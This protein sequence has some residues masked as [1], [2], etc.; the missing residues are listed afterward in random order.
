MPRPVAAA[1]AALVCGACTSI[2]VGHPRDYARAELSCAGRTYTTSSVANLEIV[3]WN[4]HGPPN[5]PV[6][7]D[8]LK[9]IAKA[10]G[11]QAPDL[12]VFQEVWF[13]GDYRT[14]VDAMQGKYAVV[15]DDPKVTQGGLHGWF[16]FR[17]GGLV[18]F[19][20]KDGRWEVAADDVSKPA[21][22]FTQYVA[23]AP[24]VISEFDGASGKG[25]QSFV[26]ASKDHQYR[27]Q[28][29]NTHLQS[30][31]GD[32]KRYVGVRRSQVNELMQSAGQSWTKARVDTQIMLGDFNTRPDEL[33]IYDRMTESFDDL[34]AIPRVALKCAGSSLDYEKRAGSELP[35][36]VEAD[37]I[38]YALAR[39]AT[40]VRVASFTLVVSTALDTPYSDHQGL[41][42]GLSIG[43]RP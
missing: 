35:V 34:T 18:A 19:V 15:A 36:T 21:E 42:L 31:Y 10:V 39:R 28:V 33:L 4:L 23:E 29:Y 16:G 40:N 11:E 27:V 32:Q 38:D 8:R 14:L 43:R 5:V 26:L 25:F 37:R 9:L 6:M 13:E 41:S 17:K 3:T 1:L 24:F 7:T 30:Q 2:H 12:A 22:E 20:R